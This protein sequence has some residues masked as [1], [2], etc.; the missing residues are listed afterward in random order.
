APPTATLFPCT[1]LFR[2]IRVQV[3]MRRPRREET[4]ATRRDFLKEA[5]SAGVGLAVASSLDDGAYAADLAQGRAVA[6]GKADHITILHTRS[7]EHTSELQ[8]L[9]HLV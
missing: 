9:R 5:G 6:T 4:M 3:C 7:E 8:S 2:S 1:T